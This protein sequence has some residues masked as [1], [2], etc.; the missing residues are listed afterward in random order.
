M[1]EYRKRDISLHMNFKKSRTVGQSFSLMKEV[2]VNYFNTWCNDA[3]YP[4]SDDEDGRLALA[5]SNEMKESGIRMS[6]F[7]FVGSVLDCY[8]ISQKRIRQFMDRSL[9]I[10]EICHPGC[11]V[12]HPG[13]F[14]EGGFSFNKAAYKEALESWGMEKT[15]ELLT[16]NI[17]YFGKRAGEFH[18]KIGV[19]NLFLGRFFSKPDELLKLVHDVDNEYVGFCF[20]SGHANV[21]GLELP[22]LIKGMGDK[23]FEVHLHDNFGDRDTHLPIGFGNINWYEVI[24]ALDEISY[25]GTA[26][27]EFFRWPLGEARE[28]ILESI[29]IWKNLEHIAYCGYNTSELG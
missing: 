2:G 6:S 28:G 29:A 5:I 18:T 9:R 21:D 15:Y 8:D 20:D 7:H 19:E 14:T 11:V 22:A 27:F 10:F 17:R 13:T 25:R 4:D 12:V 16:D 23:L 1:S 26:T 3:V 24:K